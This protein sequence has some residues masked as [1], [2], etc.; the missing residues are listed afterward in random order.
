MAKPV[1]GFHAVVEFS[2]DEVLEACG[3]VAIA[4][5]AL[6]RSGDPAVDQLTAVFALLEQRVGI[7]GR[8]SDR[9][10]G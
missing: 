2:K 9:P 1:P 6:S 4:H 5:R 8:S 3:R 10:P 7:A